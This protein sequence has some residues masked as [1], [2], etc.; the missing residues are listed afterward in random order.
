MFVDERTLLLGVALEAGLI[1]RFEIG[2]GAFDC[3]TGVHIMAIAAAH[4]A[5]EHRVGVGQ[6]EFAAF[7]EVA[8]E[9]AVGLLA[10]IV[11]EHSAAAAGLDVL[12]AGAVTRF[13]TDIQSLV[14]LDSQFRVSRVLESADQLA[15]A[16]GALGAPDKVGA[17][18]LGGGDDGTVNT[19]ASEEE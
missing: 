11:D 13:A 16:G 5:G 19:R 18:D 10:G 9:A 6:A 17:G 2:T 15:V 14:G 1:L 3:I 7:I 12:A 8:L 4:L